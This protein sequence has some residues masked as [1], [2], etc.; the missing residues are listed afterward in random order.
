MRAVLGWDGMTGMFSM[1]DPVCRVMCLCI[2]R[3]VSRQVVMGSAVAPRG[4]P[5]QQIAPLV[6]QG[7]P[8]LATVL[9]V[10]VASGAP[11]ASHAT[12]AP[13]K[14]MRRVMAMKRALV[15]VVRAGL[16]CGACGMLVV[17]QHG[18][19]CAQAPGSVCVT[20]GSL[21]ANATSAEP[22]LRL[23]LAM[24]VSRASTLRERVIHVHRII[25]GAYSVVALQRHMVWHSTF[26][27]GGS[28]K[29]VPP[30][31]CG[32]F[33]FF[34]CRPSCTLC[35]TCQAHATCDGAGTLNGTGA[36]VCDAGWAPP[37]CTVCVEGR[38]GSTC[39]ECKEG[40]YGPDCKP[41]PGLIE[42]DGSTTVC[43][44]HGTCDGSGTTSGTG[45]CQCTGDYSGDV[46]QDCKTGF[47][48]PLC[49]ACPACVHGTCNG[50]GTQSGDGTC[51]CDSGE[52][53]GS[54][55]NEC[56]Y[57]YTKLAD[58]KCA[59]QSPF[60]GPECNLC[61]T[62]HFGPNCAACPPCDYGTCNGTGTQSGDGTCVCESG[63]FTGPKC[64]QCKWPWKMEKFNNGCV[65]PSPWA[66]ENC[67]KCIGGHFGPNCTACA[68]CGVHGT[69]NGTGTQS[70][71]GVCVCDD[72]KYSGSSCQDCEWPYQQRYGRCV[73][74][75]PFSGD[76]GQCDQCTFNRY[77][78]NCTHQ[79][80]AP[81]P[82]RA[83]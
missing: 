81:L 3:L 53:T 83:G 50:T 28:L 27:R 43:G 77:G 45:Q 41:C 25:G 6:R 26:N 65:C 44:G 22:T 36:C 38:T 1:C 64:D 74:T 60:G 72:E 52:Y 61:N 59:C 16:C 67:D 14:C 5:S 39:S 70:G 37:E 47:W 55:C 19:A 15:R 18:L 8:P 49:A 82:Q 30:C 51:V 21:A 56:K 78:P 76:N 13:A 71:N 31:L 68:A 2:H 62:G 34:L 29:L 9:C 23:L 57:P 33:T 20:P 32:W 80:S 17:T 4:G 10:P 58:G 54:L 69:C 48:G 79:V 24:I 75:S 63:G 12:R 42:A 40:Y 66:G 73:C 35:P 11:L 46:C 7:T